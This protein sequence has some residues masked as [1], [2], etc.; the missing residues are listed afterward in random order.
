M[1]IFDGAEA[2]V[3]DNKRL[4]SQF[5][6]VFNLMVDGNWRTLKEISEA[7][8]APEASVSAML[9][10]FRRKKFGGHVVNRQPRSDR[11]YGLYEYQLIP[12]IQVEGEE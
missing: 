12:N 5:E 4:L 10:C 11:R 8:S 1:A 6:R 2:T 3:A 7:A 9:R